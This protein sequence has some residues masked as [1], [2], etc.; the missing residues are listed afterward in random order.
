MKSLSYNII[1]LNTSQK[2][3]IDIFYIYGEIISCFQE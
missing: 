2:Y 1:R 3:S